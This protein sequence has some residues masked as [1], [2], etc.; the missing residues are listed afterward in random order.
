MMFWWI[1][2]CGCGYACG[3][4]PQRGVTRRSDRRRSARRRNLANALRRGVA[5]GESPEDDP[6]ERR[7]EKGLQE[8]EQGSSEEGR[9]EVGK[10][11]REEVREEVGKEGCQEGASQEGGKEE[12]PGTEGTG[13][14]EATGSGSPGLRRQPSRG[15]GRLRADSGRT[16]WTGDPL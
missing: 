6:Q 12:G 8:E 4:P 15:P 1:E 3:T 5:C 11:G 2:F 13:S 16:D 7:Q 10:E 9:Q 14:R